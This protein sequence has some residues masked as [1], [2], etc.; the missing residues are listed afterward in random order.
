MAPVT[1]TG[2]TWYRPYKYKNHINGDNTDEYSIVFRLEEAYFIKAEA[3]AKQNL[4]DDAMPYL[5]ATR[6]RS[7]LTDLV[8]TSEVDFFNELLAEAT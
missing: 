6:E 7:G 2:N 5:N 3:Q 4:F 8:F 1:Y